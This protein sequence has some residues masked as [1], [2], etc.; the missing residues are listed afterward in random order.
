MNDEPMRLGVLTAGGDCPGLNAVIRAV[1]RKELAGFGGTVFGFY[2][3]WRGLVE[4]EGELLDIDRLR[5][6]LPRGGTILGTSRLTP[7]MVEQGT[8]KVRATMANRGLDAVVVI[9]G[10]GSLACASRVFDEG[11]APVIGVPKTIDNDIFGTD[12]TFGF[13]T[14]VAIATDAIDRLH[15]TAESHNRVMIVEVMG[16]NVGHIA[17]WAGLAGGATLTLIPEDPFDIEAVC[18][19]L[20]RRHERGKFASIVVVAEGARPLSRHIDRSRAGSGPVR[21][22]SARRDRSRDRRRGR[23]PHRFRDPRDGSGPCPARWHAHR[24]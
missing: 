15:T 14:A 6:T 11:L 19:S 7:Y 18:E 13:D 10:E 8:D 23:G 17:T 16:R 12:R 20:V 1:V 4:D 21:P 24:L 3:G 5:G 9:G 22:S 2:D